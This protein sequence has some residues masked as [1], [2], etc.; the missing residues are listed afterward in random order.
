MIWRWKNFAKSILSD[1]IVRRL[2]FFTTFRFASGR[3]NATLVSIVLTKNILAA[4]LNFQSVLASNRAIKLYCGRLR[5]L[6]SHDTRQNVKLLHLIYGL[7]QNEPI[8]YFHWALIERMISTIR[9]DR[10]L[11]HYTY[12]PQGV[13]WEKIKKK[14]CAVKVPPFEY[15]GIAHLKHYAHKAD[16]VR[17]LALYEMGGLYLDID[18]LVFKSFDGLFSAGQLILGVERLRGS[19][20]P[21]G[22][23]NAAMLAP[24]NHGGIRA[25][26]Q[27]YMYFR[28]KAGKHW[29]EHSV[30]LPFNLLRRRGDVKVLDSHAFFEINW[31]EANLF[32]DS[33]QAALVKARVAG[34]YS[35]HLWETKCMANLLADFEAATSANTSFLGTQL[36][37]VSYESTGWPGPLHSNQTN[38]PS[39]THTGP[40]AD[41][42][43]T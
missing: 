9:P 15:Y 6:A 24:R 37:A 34:A 16:V 23:C 14:V 5:D 35:Q 36:S 29:E 13:Y 8:H 32:F 2:T 43:S 39:Y 11:F 25:W 12:E 38:F 42:R 31:D 30:R 41:L 21:C 4:L 26:L 28:G 10:V 3:P 22:L 20:E 18:T 7:K 33:D 17:L 40:D 27:S 1:R 19:A